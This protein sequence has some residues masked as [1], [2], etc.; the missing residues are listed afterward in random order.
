[1]KLHGTL[2]LLAALLLIA[3]DTAK[4]DGAKKEMDKL[5]GTW[6]L[7]SGEFSGKPLAGGDLE[8]AEF[9]IKGDKYTFKQ[10]EM[11]EEGT[12]KV[13]PS[14]KPPTVD[15]AITSGGDK[16]K[17]QLGIYKLEGDKFTVCFSKAGAT[18][19][20]AALSTK[21]DSD[22]LLFGFKKEKAEK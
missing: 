20:P 12:I 6:K 19:R 2:G 17:A 7:V 5:Q 14:K 9:T 11:T 1:M 4:D 16:G 15:L 21:E 3:A 13:D 22:Q 8:G 10:G 18:E